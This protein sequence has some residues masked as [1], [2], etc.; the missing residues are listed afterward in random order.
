[1]NIQEIKRYPLFGILASRHHHSQHY[2]TRWPAKSAEDY[3]IGKL[4]AKRPS[5][6]T[7]D[8]FIDHLLLQVK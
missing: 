6:W 8:G 1:M 3:L 4:S 5:N 7:M 2:Y